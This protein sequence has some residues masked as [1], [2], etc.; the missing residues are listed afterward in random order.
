MIP[1]ARAMEPPTTPNPPVDVHHAEKS[2]DTEPATVASA[3]KLGFAV[4]ERDTD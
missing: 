4:A 3:R 1:V 2:A